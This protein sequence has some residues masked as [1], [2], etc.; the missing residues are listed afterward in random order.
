LRRLDRNS[1][2]GIVEW[3]V[4][5]YK[6]G[7]MEKVSARSRYEYDRALNLVLRH[8]TTIGTEVGAAPIK[9]MTTLGV[10]KIYKA[11]QKGDEGQEAP[12]PG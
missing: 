6:R 7:G 10:E 3:M 12:A 1:G 4:E 9:T 11:L 5:R 2:V 8:K